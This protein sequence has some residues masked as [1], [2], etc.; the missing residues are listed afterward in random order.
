MNYEVRIIDQFGQSVRLPKAIKI[1]GSTFLIGG[2]NLAE[3]KVTYNYSPHYRDVW[4]HNLYGIDGLS[5]ADTQVL[6]QKAV[7]ELGTEESSDYWRATR[8]NAGAALQAIL[9]VMEIC[10]ENCRVEVI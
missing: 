4:G 9:D 6:L 10:P 3:I 7:E 8:G 2:N 1:E 5:T